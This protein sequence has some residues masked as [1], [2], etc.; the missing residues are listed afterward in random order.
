MDSLLADDVT[1]LKLVQL[2]SALERRGLTIEGSKSELIDRLQAAL[3]HEAAAVL[4]KPLKRARVDSQSDSTEVPRRGAAGRSSGTDSPDDDIGPSVPHSATVAE[5][6][7]DDVGPKV[8]EG[9]AKNDS[10]EDDDIGPA[11]PLELGG[12]AETASS[13]EGSSPPSEAAQQNAA[14]K[15]AVR[16][17]ALRDEHAYL[18]ALPSAAMYERSYMHRATLTHV[19]TTPGTD[20]IVTA[21]ADGVIKFWKKLPGEIEFVKT[22]RAHLGPVVGLAASHDGLRLASIGE[23][24]SLKVFD[25]LN[26]DLTDM[27]ALPFLVRGRAGHP[28]IP[29]AGGPQ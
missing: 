2:R 4:S 12:V 14:L 23:D 7:D 22:Y 5:D 1:N 9:L 29:W 20:F 10:D 8:P 3:R 25:V 6:E 28:T 21:S 24:R 19:V 26:F 17:R 13:A 27:T 15:E 11:V 16:R 18:E